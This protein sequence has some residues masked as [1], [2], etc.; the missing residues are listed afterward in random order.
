MASCFYVE[1]LPQRFYCEQVMNFYC[2]PTLEVNREPAFVVDGP[3]ALALCSEVGAWQPEEPSRPGMLDL[4]LFFVEDFNEDSM[5]EPASAPVSMMELIFFSSWCSVFSFD[6]VASS[7][8]S[9]SGPNLSAAHGFL[10]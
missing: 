4:D 10:S 7:L 9:T 5:I 2:S 1:P 6:F 3:L 8:K